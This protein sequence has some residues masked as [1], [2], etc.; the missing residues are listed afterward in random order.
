MSFILMME[1]LN[2]QQLLLQFSVTQ[3]FFRNHFK[4]ANLLLKKHLILLFL[5]HDSLMKNSKEQHYF[6]RNIF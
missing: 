6:N 5:Q 1:K 3:Q 4:Y 2:I